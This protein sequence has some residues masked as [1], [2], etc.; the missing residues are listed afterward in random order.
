[1]QN[2]HAV[3]HISRNVIIAIGVVLLALPVAL[4]IAGLVL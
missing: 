2:H 1:M 4:F 3:G